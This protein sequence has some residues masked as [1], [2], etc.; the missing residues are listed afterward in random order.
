MKIFSDQD[1]GQHDLSKSALNRWDSVG[2]VIVNLFVILLIIVYLSPLAYLFVNSLKAHEQLL[3]SQ[4]PLWPAE[5]EMYNYQGKNYQMF[6]VPTDNG[7]KG[8]AL[9][10][11]HLKYSEFVDPENPDAGL[12]RWDGQWKN[13]N[14]IYHFK[15]TFSNFTSIL[16]S[17]F[18]PP[19]A[20][21]TFLLALI[22]EV[23]VLCSSISVA[24]GFSRFRIPGGKWLFYALIGTIMIPDS[25]TLLPTYFLYTRF[26]HWNGTWYPLLVPLLFSNA[27]FVF[28]LRQN[29]KSIP[30]EQDEAAMLD[31]A[32]PLRILVSIILPQSLPAVTTVALL[33]FFYVWNEVRISSLFLGTNSNLRPLSYIVQAYRAYG[34]TPEKLEA[35]ALLML[36][37]PVVILL[38]T[39]R[40][41]MQDMVVTGLE[42]RGAE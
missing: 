3:D 16:Q 27:V 26:L 10:K 2:T 11:P 29:F 35:G 8:M 38:L 14:G 41:F 28:L 40:F 6:E 19:A 23:L 13:L 31:G 5:A 17:T 4:A 20:M 33:H 18:F 36:A 1:E 9:V 30:R 22:G 24:Y 7:I 21:N 12:I 15:V 34:F 42:K 37:V 25:I 39:H 32:G